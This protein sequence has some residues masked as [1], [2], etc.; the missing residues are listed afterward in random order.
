MKKIILIVLFLSLPSISH[1]NIFTETISR[2]IKLKYI[3]YTVGSDVYELRTGIS[4]DA[5]SLSDI[6]RSYGAI[7]GING[8]FFCPAD[9]SACGWKNYTINERFV[10]GQDL[11]F[12][13]DTGE[14]AVFWWDSD[15]VP[16][17]HKTGKINPN[18]RTDI[19]EWLWNFPILYS[20]WVNFLEHYHDVGLY[21]NKM[22]ANIP[23]HFICANKDKTEIFFG[24]SSATS[25]DGLAPALF[26][27]WCWDGINLDAGA[28]T[29]FNY[30]GRELETWARKV[31]D[32]F[33]IVPKWFDAKLIH[34]KLDSAMP[35]ITRIFKKY[36]K[37]KALARITA[38]REYIKKYRD[39]NY[40]KFSR[41]IFDKNWDPNGY[42]LEVTDTQV[43]QKIYL[44][45]ILDIQ[46][47]KLYNDIFANE[48][49]I[50]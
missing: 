6:S 1:G 14:R 32:W 42:T 40:K 13:T 46:L 23:R 20:N 31:L 38:V 34:N 35:E 12:Y 24:S 9:Y 44:F 48:S 37:D 22:A 28:S 4:E 5:Q 8:V 49:S 45:N 50:F 3:S 39:D 29:F 43:L 47:R 16:F 41:E 7:S 10:G 19:F 26:D 2:D 21:D 11:S 15:T 17:L 33:F 25:L 27:I 30:N 36:P 18:K